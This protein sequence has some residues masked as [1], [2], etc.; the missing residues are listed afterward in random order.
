MRF[1][2]KRDTLD[3]AYATLGM[4]NRVGA[5]ATLGMTGGG[6]NARSVCW[7][8]AGSCSVSWYGE[9]RVLV[10]ITKRVVLPCIRLIFIDKLVYNIGMGTRD[11][12]CKA[13]PLYKNRKR[14]SLL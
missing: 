14:K 8:G 3:F 6:V 4:T 11:A 5:D 1:L 9:G 12:F 2:E 7:V 10:G 13:K